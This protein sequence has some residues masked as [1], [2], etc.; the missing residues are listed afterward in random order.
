MKNCLKTS[1][2]G[3]DYGIYSGRF[4]SDSI[5]FNHSRAFGLSENSIAIFSISFRSFRTAIGLTYSRVIKM[6]GTLS[7][8]PGDSQTRQEREG[9]MSPSNVQN[10]SYQHNPE[11]IRRQHNVRMMTLELEEGEREA[12]LEKTI[13]EFPLFVP[14]DGPNFL[15]LPGGIGPGSRLRIEAKKGR[16]QITRGPKN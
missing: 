5:F 9:D 2:K 11:Y 3:D 6:P 12:A 1:F 14:D 16:I 13:R 10:L 8:A 7:E 4:I 15:T